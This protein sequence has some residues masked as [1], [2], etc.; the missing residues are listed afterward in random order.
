MHRDVCKCKGMVVP[1]HNLCSDLAETKDELSSYQFLGFRRFLKKVG[2]EVMF[3]LT[4]SCYI[5]IVALS[6][7]K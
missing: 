4:E 5:I 3:S 6:Y 2:Y 1:C 7:F